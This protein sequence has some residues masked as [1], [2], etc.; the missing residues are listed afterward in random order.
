M[1]KDMGMIFER[2]SSLGI[3]YPLYNLLIDHYLINSNKI[4]KITLDNFHNRKLLLSSHS[5]NTR[6]GL[7]NYKDIIEVI[8]QNK[9]ALVD[10]LEGRK[11]LE[12]INAIYESVETGKEV[13]LRFKPR[14]CKLGG[15]I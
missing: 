8:R 6:S 1:K 9:K 3:P 14:E 5:Y 12:L 15:G 4:H 2:F 10:G 11:S 7:M 13:F